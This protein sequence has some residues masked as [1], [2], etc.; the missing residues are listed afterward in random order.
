MRL[1]VTLLLLIY[2]VIQVFGVAFNDLSCDNGHNEF[3]ISLVV[4][5][6]QIIRKGNE[7]VNSIT[8]SRSINV[9]PQSSLGLDSDKSMNKTAG[10]RDASISDG[11]S[12]KETTKLEVA[13]ELNSVSSM[14]DIHGKNPSQKSVEKPPHTNQTLQPSNSDDV[15]VTRSTFSDNTTSISSFPVNSPSLQPSI[16]NLKQPILRGIVDPISHRLHDPEMPIPKTVNYYNW[17]DIDAGRFE[18]FIFKARL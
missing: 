11:I 16:N 5:T 15:N 14:N 18:N 7:L 3:M 17:G 13:N 8:H 9:S 1:S 12:N 2:T 10:M 4:R 6:K